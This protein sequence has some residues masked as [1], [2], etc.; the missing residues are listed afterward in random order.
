MRC[1]GDN[2]V[3]GCVNI[4]ETS[5]TAALSGPYD[6]TLKIAM[7]G[8]TF[9]A[10]TAP[11]TGFVESLAV[12]SSEI[13]RSTHRMAIRPPAPPATRV[14]G[15]PRHDLVRDPAQP[16]PVVLALEPQHAVAGC[17]AAV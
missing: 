4:R 15:A 2:S 14:R 1:A 11:A 16:P 13:P 5:I 7:I 8:W 3:G 12:I 9:D 6:S 17:L 10:A